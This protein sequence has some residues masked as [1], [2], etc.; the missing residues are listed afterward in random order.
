MVKKTVGYVELEWTCKRCGTKNPGT[1]KT[2]TNCGGPMTEGEAFELPAEQVLIKDEGKLAQAG[3]G[4]DII[5]P[6]CS[7]RNPAGTAACIQCGGDLKDAKAREQGQ[8]LGAYQSGPAPQVKCP[9]CGTLNVANAP[10]CVNCGASLAKEPAPTPKPLPTPARRGLPW[11]W[12][13]LGVLGL[14]LCVALGALLARG[15]RTTANLASVQDI[16]WERSIQILELRPV[17]RQDWQDE[18]PAEAE[19]NTCREEL[20][21]T[22]S[23]PAPGAVEVCG[24][25]YTEDEGSGLGRVV[26]DCEYQIYA[27][28][29]TYTAEEW[30]VT[31]TS[32]LQGSD[33]SP[34]WPSLSLVAG[35]QA[36]DRVER[37]TVTFATAGG[38]QYTYT[39]SDPAEFA[40]FSPG[41]Q[42]N[43]Q[44]N[45]FGSLVG[46]EP[47]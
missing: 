28:L 23:E 1:A 47:K 41:S 38:E 37:Y 30:Q 36:G 45:G 2:C 46:V 44:I 40:Q 3:K 14:V 15:S 4:P 33:L 21:E 32:A 7:T 29:C 42:W 17:Q 12:I 6:Y 34:A 27:N 26:Q 19:I 9:A 31:D 25:P 18:I 10:R 35:Q 43:L 16:R 11:L 22:R 13:G 39:T 20:R 8:V 24:T 5:C